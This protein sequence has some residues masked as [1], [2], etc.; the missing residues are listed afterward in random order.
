MKEMKEMQEAQEAYTAAHDMCLMLESLLR[1]RVN[2]L[3]EDEARELAI[4]AK[5]AVR[6]FIEPIRDLMRENHRLIK[7]APREK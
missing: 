5:Q 4:A 2:P 1:Q 6:L 3:L 7:P